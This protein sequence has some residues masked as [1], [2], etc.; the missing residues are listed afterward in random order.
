LTDDNHSRATAP[1]YSAATLR[2]AIQTLET[3]LGRATVDAIIDDLEKQGLRLYSDANHTIQEIQTAFDNIFGIETSAY[4]ID[5][6]TK[7]LSAMLG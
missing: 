2:V 5:R 3:L 4:L 6:V 1:I 7:T